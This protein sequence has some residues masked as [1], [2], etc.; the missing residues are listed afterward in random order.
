MS[1]EKYYEARNRALRT[2]SLG[3]IFLIFLPIGIPVSLIII[4]FI[5]GKNGASKLPKEWHLTYIITV[6]GGWALGLVSSIF[7]LLSLAL[8]PSLQI[9]IAEPIIFAVLLVFTWFSFTIGVKSTK[10]TSMSVGPYEQEWEEEYTEESL[11]NDDKKNETNKKVESKKN[12]RV[13]A[14]P[15]EYNDNKSKDM[16]SKV[17]NFITGPADNDKTIKNNINKIS[18]DTSKTSR[19]S[20]LASRRRK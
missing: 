18:N 10:T 8:G 6:G 12:K 13:L 1:L 3:L 11:S 2:M 15:N 16:F 7:L 17:K 4:P 20:A 9:N 14:I 5:A 19:V